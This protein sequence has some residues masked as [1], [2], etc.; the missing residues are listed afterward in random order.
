M[1][2][3]EDTASDVIALAQSAS[4]EGLSSGRRFLRE[5]LLKH[6]ND[7]SASLSTERTAPTWTAAASSA[8]S[9]EEN[10][11]GGTMHSALRRE[12]E[13]PSKTEQ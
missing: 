4:R 3:I 9:P 8:D 13:T 6:P 11:C 10:Q 5:S 1:H 7:I 12:A 2:S